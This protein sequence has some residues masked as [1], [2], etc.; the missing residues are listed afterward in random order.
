MWP[1]IVVNRVAKMRSI[2][3]SRL[4]GWYGMMESS[5][6]I[7]LL[8]ISLWRYYPKNRAARLRYW[9]FKF[10]DVSEWCL[11]YGKFFIFVWKLVQNFFFHLCMLKNWIWCLQSCKKVRF[12][13]PATIFICSL[14]FPLLMNPNFESGGKKEP[15][16]HLTL[17][18]HFW[19]GGKCK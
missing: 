17:S 16:K 15:E 18:V 7:W 10:F 12:D 3:M 1:S 11:S 8:K 5:K 4:K 13:E 9:N 19:L 2:F 6:F 14:K